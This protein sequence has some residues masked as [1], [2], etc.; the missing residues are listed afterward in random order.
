MQG[1]TVAAGEHAGK[2]DGILPGLPRSASLGGQFAVS[3]IPA[4]MVSRPPAGIASRAF[5]AIA[6]DRLLKAA[7]VDFYLP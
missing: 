6:D 2:A 4:S 1:S 5:T 7:R 3:M